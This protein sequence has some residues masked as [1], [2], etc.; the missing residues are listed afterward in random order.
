MDTK[1]TAKTFF[2]ASESL[3]SASPLCLQRSKLAQIFHNAIT[4][5]FVRTTAE[6]RLDLWE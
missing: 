3:N 4:P 2:K 5:E 6:V 1:K